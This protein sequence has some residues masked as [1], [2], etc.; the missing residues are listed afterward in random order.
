VLPSD[1]DSFRIGLSTAVS[2]LWFVVCA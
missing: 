2:V 1:A